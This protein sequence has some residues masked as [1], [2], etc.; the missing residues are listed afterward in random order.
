MVAPLIKKNTL[1]QTKFKLTEH[2]F[3][4]SGLNYS[5]DDVVETK[6]I[7]QVFELKTVFVGSDYT[8][9]ISILFTMKSGENI[10]LTEQSTMTYTS[11]LERVEHIQNIFNTV[12]SKSF[13]ARVSKYIKQVENQGF[14]EYSGWRFFPEQKKLINIETKRAYSTQA[15]SFL[16]SYGFIEVVSKAEGLGEKL[17]RKIKGSVGINTLIDTDVFFALLKHFFNLEW[18]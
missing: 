3:I 7:R 17:S 8:H 5:F 12:S 6:S 2:G 18:K 15:T 11:K 14:Y 10:Q 13:N 9:S 1:E 4:S 16:K